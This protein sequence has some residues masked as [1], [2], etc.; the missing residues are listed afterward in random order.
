MKFRD[1]IILCG[2]LATSFFVGRI[3]WVQSNIKAQL[4]PV[5]QLEFISGVQGELEDY[6]LSDTFLDSKVDAWYENLSPTARVGQLIMP[7]WDNQ[8]SV[9]DLGTLIENETIGG[10]MILNDSFTADAIAELEALNPN[11]G[12]LLV[13]VDAEPSLLK[14]RFEKPVFEKETSDLKTVTEINKVSGLIADDL[15]RFGMNLNFAPV[16]DLGTNTTVIGDRAFSDEPE[17]VQT[18]AN[19]MSKAFMQKNVIP[20]AKHFP[21]HGTVTG[22]THLEL[23]TIT[24]ALTELPQFKSAIKAQ[25]P[26]VM[27]GHLAIENETY[28]TK[29]LPSTLSPAI[30]TNLL[31]EEMG[32]EGVIITDAMNMLAVSD[33]EDADLLSLIAGADIALMPLEAEK[34]N[35]DIQELL[36]AEPLFQPDFEAKIKRVLRLKLVWRL[37]QY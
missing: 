16:Y 1:L 24:D 27:V 19:L 22:D 5:P 6:F 10:F 13:S 29:G 31:R 34:L 20:T 7:A 28:D 21:G 18:R 17:M 15:K 9:A 12:P 14:Y 23:Q 8:T 25:I 4:M 30:M 33:I 36:M 37:S 3:E 32:F 2:V 35:Q 26:V 11:K